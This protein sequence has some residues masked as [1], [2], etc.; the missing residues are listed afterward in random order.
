MTVIDGD[1][2][3]L[4]V[5]TLYR[6]PPTDRLRILG[7]LDEFHRDA[8]LGAPGFMTVAVHVSEESDVVMVYA[9]WRDRAAFDACAAT[10]VTHL[11]ATR[12]A[13]FRAEQWVMDV[14]LEAAS[15]S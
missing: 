1:R 6:I 15:A 2:P 3:C 12:L 11:A 5:V 14:A 9:Q 10:P 4:T 7:A 8:V 13:E